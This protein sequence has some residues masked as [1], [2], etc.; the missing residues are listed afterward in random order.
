M[1]TGKFEGN[2]E[3]ARVLVAVGLGVS[4]AAVFE[5]SAAAGD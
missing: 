3:G 4:E 1:P 5:A 2:E